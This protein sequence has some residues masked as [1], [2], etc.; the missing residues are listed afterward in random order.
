MRK[1][2]AAEKEKSKKYSWLR[3]VGRSQRELKSYKFRTET[4]DSEQSWERCIEWDVVEGD[5][6]AKNVKQ[7]L[8]SQ[9]GES[10]TYDKEH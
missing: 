6:Q 2:Y 7:Q 1:C 3:I 10:N 8:H 4:T 5:L 9:K